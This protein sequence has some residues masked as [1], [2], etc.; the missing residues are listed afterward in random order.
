MLRFVT[1]GKQP[2]TT[3]T[4]FAIIASPFLLVLF[5]IVC[6]AQLIYDYNFVAYAAREAT[7]YAAVHG[8][9]SSSPAST[10]DVQ[11]LVVGQASGLNSQKLTVN[12]TWSPDNHPGSVVNVSVSYTYA[13][14]VP[15]FGSN[16]INLSSRSQMV[17]SH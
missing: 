16:T 6:F 13:F 15:M 2:G 11:N 3:S 14:P 9:T 7:R 17:I 1:S 12:T 4:E 8:S 10:T 5:A